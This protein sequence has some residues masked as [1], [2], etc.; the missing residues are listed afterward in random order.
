MTTVVLFL[1][2]NFCLFI[3]LF[4]AVLGPHCCVGFSLV[5]EQELLSS[6][7]VRASYCSGFSCCRVQALEHVGFRS[8]SSPTLDHR[9]S[10]YGSRA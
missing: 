10:S 7:G 8:C 6:R 4:L 2:Y 9:L 3:S 5:V 1:K